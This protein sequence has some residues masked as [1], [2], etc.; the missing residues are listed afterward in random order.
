M[1]KNIVVYFDYL[2]PYAWRGAEFTKMI[3]EPL[4]L[5]FDWRHYSLYQGNYKGDDSWQLWEDTI[6]ADVD[7]KN[8]SKGLIP[9]LASHYVKETMPEKY[10]AFRLNLQ[11][12]G[13]TDAK[14]FSLNVV[15]DI[16]KASGISEDIDFDTKA[17]RNSL[18]VAHEE[19]LSKNVVATPTF[20]LD[21]SNASYFRIEQVPSSETEAVELFK[22]Y[23]ELLTKYPYFETLRRP[24][25]NKNSVHF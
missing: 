20:F 8:G 18:K 21:D 3:E 24:K 7:N 9:F 19:A 6:D 2:C 13:H 17:L 15:K 1:N 16:L 10:D 23:S 25:R 11:R 4:G 22:H 12:A 5:T 14:G